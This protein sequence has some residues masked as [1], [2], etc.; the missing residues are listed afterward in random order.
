M[1]KDG[2]ATKEV[3]LIGGDSMPSLT[4][5]SGITHSLASSREFSSRRIGDL[6]EDNW[7]I[8]EEEIRDKHKLEHAPNDLIIGWKAWMIRDHSQV[9]RPNKSGTAGSSV[10]PTGSSHA[11]PVSIQ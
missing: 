9:H 4:I 11:W 5:F 3:Y 10:L 1:K 7:S 6:T 2:I 8:K